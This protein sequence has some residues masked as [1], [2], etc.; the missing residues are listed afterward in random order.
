M[1]EAVVA[2]AS[3]GVGKDLVGL[4]GFLEPRLGFLVVRVAVGVI[5]HRELSV[6]RLQCGGVGI[7]G[8]PEDFVVVA[9]F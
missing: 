5:L 9:F 7:A 3:L 4:R 1:T 6:G 8:D 2:R